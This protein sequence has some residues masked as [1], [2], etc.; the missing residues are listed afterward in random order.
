MLYRSTASLLLP[1]TLGI[2][3]IIIVFFF[4]INIIMLRINKYYYSHCVYMMKERIEDEAK[5][6]NI[7]RCKR[8]VRFRAFFF[9]I[10]AQCLP[11]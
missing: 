1:S 7:N 4:I 3:N 10:F 5:L 11:L 9:I 2:Y 6:S 8:N